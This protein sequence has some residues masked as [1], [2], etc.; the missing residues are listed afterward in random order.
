MPFKAAVY[1]VDELLLHADAP[2]ARQQ[3]AV[4]AT[5]PAEELD[6]WRKRAEEIARKYQELMQSYKHAKASL[7]NEAEWRQRCQKLLQAALRNCRDL[8]LAIQAARKAGGAA[9]DPGRTAL[10][11]G[12]EQVVE[13]QLQQLHAERLLEQIEPQPSELFDDNLHQQVGTKPSAELAAGLIA[14]V[15]EP[16]YACGGKAVRKAKVLLAVGL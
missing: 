1:E 4:P 14:E 9:D 11:A 15:V 5:S 12:I 10:I 13:N 16:G 7:K 2:P 3:A 6:A 8:E